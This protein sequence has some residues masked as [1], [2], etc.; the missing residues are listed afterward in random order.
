MS[1]ILVLVLCLPSCSGMNK[2]PATGRISDRPYTRPT[3]FMPTSKTPDPRS[4]PARSTRDKLEVVAMPPDMT[5]RIVGMLKAIPMDTP[6]LPKSTVFFVDHAA[7]CQ[8]LGVNRHDYRDSQGNTNFESE[9]FYIEDVVISP[10]DSPDSTRLVWSSWLGRSP[11]ISGMGL[12]LGVMS[13]RDTLKKLPVRT[14][15]IGYGPLDVDRSIL[16]LTLYQDTPSFFEA[17]QGVFETGAIYQAAAN[18]Q[19][20]AHSAIFSSRDGFDIYSWDGQEDYARSLNAPVFDTAG[21]GVTLAVRPSHIFGNQQ[22]ALVDS[23]IDAYQ[24]RVKSAADNAWFTALAERMESMG[25]MSAA[26]ADWYLVAQPNPDITDRYLLQREEIF[27]KSVATAPLLGPYVA[28]AAGLGVDEL[29]MFVSLALLYNS[30][31]LAG[32]DIETLETRLAE[33]YNTASRPWKLEV[34][35]YEIWTEGNVLC[36]KLRGEVIGYWDYFIGLEPLLVR[37]SDSNE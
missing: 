25:A 37:A 32:I 31:E 3:D 7:W 14:V 21:R 35:S 17:V 19:D 13:G 11:F 36:A 22:P 18:F 30:P 6:A 26:I 15:N 1:L 34:E 16:S 23:M 9:N 10:Y 2:T 8:A 20:G 28:Y 24:G 4:V 12:S 5:G 33:G 29:G 27:M